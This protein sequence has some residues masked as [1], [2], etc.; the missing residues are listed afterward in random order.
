MMSGSRKR[1]R[2]DEGDFGLQTKYFVNQQLID[3]S[4]KERMEKVYGEIFIFI[5]IDLMCGCVAIAS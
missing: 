5:M 1:R 3:K 4:N 2:S